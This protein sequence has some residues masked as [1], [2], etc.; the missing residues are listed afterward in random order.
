MRKVLQHGNAQGMETE[1]V[2]KYQINR[3][4]DVARIHIFRRKPERHE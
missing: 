4:A 2:F 1:D 3:E